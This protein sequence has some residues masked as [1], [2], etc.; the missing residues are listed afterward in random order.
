[1]AIMKAPPSDVKEIV[2]VPN[3]YRHLVERLSPGGVRPWE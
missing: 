1:M 2:E 3:N